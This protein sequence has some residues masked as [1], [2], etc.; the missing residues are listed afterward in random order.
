M[1]LSRIAR[2][3]SR[4]RGSTLW[5]RGR[6]AGGSMCTTFCP[7]AETGARGGGGGA[8]SSALQRGARKRICFWLLGA[9]LREKLTKMAREK[10]KE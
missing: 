5:N 2:R 7:M 6:V 1:S 10:S 9:A 3:A 8:G 4:D